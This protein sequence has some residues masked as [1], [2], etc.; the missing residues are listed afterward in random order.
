MTRLTAFR[1]V[2]STLIFFETA[3]RLAKSL[4]DMGAA[5]GS[6]EA[7]I[8]RELTKLHE[9]L[10]RGTLESLATDIANES[11]K[12]EVAVVIAPPRNEAEQ[13][14]DARLAADLKAALETM[15]LRDAVRAVTDAHRVK[16][17][18]VYELGLS[19]TKRGTP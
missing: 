3:P 17:A 4:A 6:R 11:V 9:T 1:D 18:R 5:L 16:R 7:V 12:G 2:P 13:V 14:D 15:T 8:A 10:Y 19:L